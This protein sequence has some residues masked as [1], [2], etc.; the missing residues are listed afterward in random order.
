MRATNRKTVKENTRCFKS[1][2]DPQLGTQMIKP[3]NHS[4]RSTLYMSQEMSSGEQLCNKINMYGRTVWKIGE[5]F[6][7]N[8]A[9]ALR[10]KGA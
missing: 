2:V 7:A 10:K 4:S 8:S 6:S 9:R 5:V 3:P 1:A